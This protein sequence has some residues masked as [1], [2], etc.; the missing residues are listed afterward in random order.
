M[1][2][3]FHLFTL[4][5]I[6]FFSFQ[7]LFP[8]QSQLFPLNAIIMPKYSPWGCANTLKLRICQYTHSYD[9]YEEVTQLIWK[10]LAVDYES[11]TVVIHKTLDLILFMMTKGASGRFIKEV[12]SRRY[13]I[14]KWTTFNWNNGEKDY[15]TTIRENGMFS[16]ISFHSF[17]TCF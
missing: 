15:S 17:V 3:F 12:N 6:S 7:P 5:F 2:H 11:S 9:A 1:S 16:F 10:R 4:L 13:N 14:A 8:S